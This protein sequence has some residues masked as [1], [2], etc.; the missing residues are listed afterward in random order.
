MTISDDAWIDIIQNE[1]HARSVGSTGR[2]DCAGM[3]K[4]VRLELGPTPF[5]LQ[6]SAAATPVITIA[7][8]RVE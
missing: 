1:R 6:L 2:R 5:V 8:S 3:R 7:I 4:S